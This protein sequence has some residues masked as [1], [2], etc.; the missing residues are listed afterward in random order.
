MPLFSIVIVS[1]N[2][3][4]EFLKTIKSV[5]K[6]KY[7]NYEIVIVDGKSEDGSINV[8]KKLKK[9]KI[10]FI[11]EKDKGIY[12]AMNKGVKKSSGEWIIFLNSGDIFYNSNVLKKISQKKVHN[13]K[14]LF[15]NTVINNQYFNYILK[16]EKFNSNTIL[17]PFCHQSSLVKRKLL[18]KFPFSLKYKIASDFDFFKKSFVRNISFYNL[19][20]V[21]SK[22]S[23]NGISDKKRNIVYDENIKIISNYSVNISLI[24]KLKIYKIIFTLKKLIKF[25]L[26]NLINLYILKFKYNK[27]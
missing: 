2:T 3:K 6:Q 5:E 14:I 20:F 18:L 24:A 27:I 9:K 12:D 1:L 25:L 4:N 19:N 13:Y 15:G 7:K 17:M 8:I 21:V 10:K 23:S 11:I 26:P 16:G 22:I